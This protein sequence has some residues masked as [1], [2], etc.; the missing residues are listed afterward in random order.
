MNIRYG[1]VGLVIAIA[2][3]C[4][5]K[6]PTGPTPLPDPGPVVTNVPPVIGKFTVQST[7]AN[8]PADFAD[9]LDDVQI[10]VVV[11]DAEPSSTELKFNW[12]AAVG[13][14]SG[15]GRSVTW[16]VPADATTPT[17]LAIN[18]EVVETY[19]SQGKSVE[20]RVTAS[21][22]VR[23]HNSL[24]EVG[25]LA[26]QFLE[27]FSTS[28]LPTNVVM[29]NFEP[30]CYGTNDEIGDVDRNRADFTIIAHRVDSPVTTI[31]FGGTCAFRSKPGDGCARVPVY[32]K[33]VAKR[34]LYDGSGVLALRAGQQ[35]EA[36]GFDQVAAK[37]YPSQ[38]RWRLCDSQF[39]GSSTSF[40]AGSR[41]ALFP[42]RGMV[43]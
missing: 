29:R 26:V 37:Y 20:N 40:G 18:V 32:W 28:S 13:S 38:N 39:D 43:P 31:R 14:F 1:V 42:L 2:V 9:V 24:K 6:K 17:D 15:T 21:T 4:G 3:A 25:D 10:S 36:S 22:T 41:R 35:S 16:K 8:V 34:D 33:S 11:T 27:D 30:D 12:S 23:L 19:T 7:R 5:G